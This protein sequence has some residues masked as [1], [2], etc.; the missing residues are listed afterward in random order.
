MKLELCTSFSRRIVE[1]RSLSMPKLTYRYKAQR[2]IGRVKRLVRFC[3]H[4]P[5][6]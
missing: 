3:Y 2:N 5:Q 6:L 4:A 1:C